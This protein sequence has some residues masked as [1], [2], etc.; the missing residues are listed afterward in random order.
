MRNWILLLGVLV[1]CSVSAQQNYLPLQ[2]QY[3]QWADRFEIQSGVVSPTFHTSVKPYTR[4]FYSDFLD[5]TSTSN[6]SKTDSLSRSYLMRETWECNS[7]TTNNRKRLLKF[8]YGKKSDFYSVRTDHFDLHVNPVVYFSGGQELDYG[9]VTINSRGAEVRGTIDRKVGFYTFFTD[10]QALLP[11][12]VNDY[13]A[14]TKVIPGE[15]FNKLFKTRG[16]DFITARGYIHFGITKHIQMQFGHDKNFIGNGYRSLVLSDFASSYNFLK[17]NTRIW[18]LNYMNL[19]TEMTANYTGADGLYPKKYMA[20]HHLSVNIGKH[21]NIG[22]FE[23]VML[24]G[25]SK[26]STKFGQFDIGYLNPIIFYRSIEQQIGSFDNAILGT[27]WK[28]N[29]LRR[30]SWYGQI[31]LDEFVLEQLKARNGWWA[32]KQALQ[33]GL[34]YVNVAG[35]K[36]LDMQGEFNYVRPY[37]Y[38]HKDY[39]RNFSHFNQPIAHPLGANFSELIGIVRYQP[40]WRM[41]MTAKAFLIKTGLDNDTTNWGGNV[42][43]DYTTIEQE[44]NNKVGQGIGADIKMISFQLTYMLF[45]NCFLDANVLLRNRSTDLPALDQK[46]T[47]LSMSLRWNIAPRLHEL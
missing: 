21:V 35:I 12:Y 37:M 9:A 45:H 15:G 47:T 28:V 41:N 18:K 39:Y 38:A 13:R 20:L 2:P 27:D 4:Q 36:N 6:V 5:S 3:Y 19:F 42:L 24:R 32:N 29:F 30:F 25:R 43:K 40:H 44:F 26:D 22:I 11:S 31:V 33:T 14:L 16:V 7:D 46:T 34:K 8:A 17:L 10:N 23:S 1:A